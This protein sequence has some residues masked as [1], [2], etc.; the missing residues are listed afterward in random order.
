MLMGTWAGARV[1]TCDFWSI[2]PHSFIKSMNIITHITFDKM[3]RTRLVVLMVMIPCPSQHL[4]NF[5]SGWV[6]EITPYFPLSINMAI[7]YTNNQQIRNVRN[8][9]KTGFFRATIQ[10]HKDIQVTTEHEKI[11]AAYP[12]FREAK[13][14][15]N[16]HS[17]NRLND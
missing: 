10:N 1:P 9:L 3:A 17:A 15:P 11:K 14:T 7:I 2:G 16:H 12:P 6:I 4:W 8:V 13:N 5:E